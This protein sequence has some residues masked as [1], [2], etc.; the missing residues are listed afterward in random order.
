MLSHTLEVPMKAKMSTL[1]VAMI[2]GIVSRPAPE[3]KLTTPLGKLCPAPT[4]S[5]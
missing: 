2:G 3:M 1:P 5:V 4:V